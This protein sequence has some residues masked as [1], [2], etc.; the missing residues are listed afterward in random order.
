MWKRMLPIL[1]LALLI[2][3]LSL[4][5]Q[6]TNQAAPSPDFDGDGMVGISDFLLFVNHFGL[7]SR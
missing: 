6:D 5:G 3:P 2:Y 4:S 1:F 7:K